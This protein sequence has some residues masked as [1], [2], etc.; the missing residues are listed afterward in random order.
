MITGY[1]TVEDRDNP[2]Y[3]ELEGPFRCEREDAWLGHGYYF[4]D[5]YQP[6]AHEW[7][8]NAYKSKGYVVCSAMISNDETIMWDLYGNVAHNLEFIAALETLLESGK[9]KSQDEILTSDVIDFLRIKGLFH[10]LSVRV[11]DLYV[12]TKKVALKHPDE[13]GRRAYMNVGERV[14]ICLFEK[15][16]LTLCDFSIIFPEKYL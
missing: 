12:Q 13:R 6:W 15:S 7:G 5:T 10:Y 2:H 14:Q 9:Y 11:G 3:I 16:E 4:W 8:K 1:H